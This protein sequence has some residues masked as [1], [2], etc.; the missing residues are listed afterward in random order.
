MFHVNLSF[1]EFQQS[2]FKDT[3]DP[4][5]WQQK[6]RGVVLGKM[7]ENKRRQWKEFT[8]TCPHQGDFL[9]PAQFP[10][11]TRAQCWERVKPMIAEV[12]QKL[13]PRNFLLHQGTATYLWIKHPRSRCYQA[14]ARTGVPE[15][16]KIY[17]G[18][19][20]GH[21][22]TLEHPRATKLSDRLLTLLNQYWR[23]RQDPLWSM[24]KTDE[25][26]KVPF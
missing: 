17:D 15:D 20:G 2:L 21:Q 16:L 25:D 19:V 5:D 24:D 4:E 18:L 1:G 3:E 12:R 22:I 6:S 8:E 11:L 14:L 13:P 7:H 9:G 10:F 23:R 26:E